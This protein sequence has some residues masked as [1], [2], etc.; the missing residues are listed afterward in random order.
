MVITKREDVTK[1]G[2]CKLPLL[3]IKIRLRGS[4]FILVLIQFQS[5]CHPSG[6]G[7]GGRLFEASRLLTFSTFRMGAY[8]KWVPIRGWALI[9]IN[10]VVV[11]WFEANADLGL[12]I[13]NSVTLWGFPVQLTIIPRARRAYWAYWLRGH[14]GERNNCFSEIQ[15]VRQKYRE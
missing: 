11:W 13:A 9:R 14:E 12:K 15:L 10:T 1:Q 8:S 5:H 2:F 4:L 3:W 7:R 6:W